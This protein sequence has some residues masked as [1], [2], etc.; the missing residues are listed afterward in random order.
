MLQITDGSLTQNSMQNLGNCLVGNLPSQSSS[1]AL[2]DYTGGNCSYPYKY[3]YNVAYYP[4]SYP[5]YIDKTEKAIK[6]LEVLMAEKLFKVT[7]V[8]NF[9]ELIKRIAKEL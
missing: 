3:K 1:S 5:V 4:Y 7:S 9:I 2:C 6:I 8:H